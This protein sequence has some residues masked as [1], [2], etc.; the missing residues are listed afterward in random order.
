VATLLIW[1]ASLSAVASAAAPISATPRAGDRLA[2]T[3]L[4]TQAALGPGWAAGTAPRS[5]PPLTCPGFAPRPARAKPTGTAITGRFAQSSSG[6]FVSQAAY[7]YASAAETGRVSHAVM[8]RRLL[9]CVAAGLSAGSGSGLVL[10]VTRKRLLDVPPVGLIATG[11]RVQGTATEPSQTVDVYLD[12]FVM[13]A[14]RAIS[15]IS[16]ASF[17]APPSRS[18]ERRLEVAVSARL[19]DQ[20]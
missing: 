12:E 16:V 5:V 3:L 19:G 11:Y 2:R 9:R 8:R 1:S 15:E 14:G 4:I 10:T 7:V 13:T 6:P 18:L 20:G 17:L